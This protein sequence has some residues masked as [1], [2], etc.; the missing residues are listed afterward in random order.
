LAIVLLIHILFAAC[1]FDIRN[2]KIPNWFIAIS[3]AAL[4]AQ[5]FFI[6]RESDLIGTFFSVVFPVLIL[7]PLFVLGLFGGADLKLLGLIGVCFSFKEVMFIFV[8]SLFFGL[9]LG[10]FKA[11]INRSFFERF[12]ALFVFS[13]NMIFR[14]R[15]KDKEVLNESYID[16]LDKDDLKKGSIH[17][18]LPILLAVVTKLIVG[19]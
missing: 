1:L 15:M 2:D 10:L 7:F 13:K 8:I 4:L 19:G 5:K 3:L 9:F 18:S 6:F 16:F 12:K 11:L 14:I 17:Y